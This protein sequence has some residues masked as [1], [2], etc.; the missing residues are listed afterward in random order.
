MCQQ[1]KPAS[2]TPVAPRRSFFRLMLAEAISLAEEVRGRPQ[3]RLSDLDQVPDEV[4]RQMAPVFNKKRAYSIENDRV[5]L[6]QKKT[7]TYQ[8]IYQLDPQE[9][10][11]LHY[12]DGQ[13]TLEAIGHRVAEKFGQDEETTYQQVKTLFIFLAK[14]VICF[15]A[16]AH[17]EGIEHG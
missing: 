8:E 15:P 9:K 12:F 11:M 5:L 17:E 1:K 10:F 4:V 7:G 6:K 2:N 14:H 3:R 13:H 16:Q